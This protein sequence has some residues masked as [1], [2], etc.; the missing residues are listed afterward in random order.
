M[1]VCQAV[2]RG[3]GTVRRNGYSRSHGPACLWHGRVQKYGGHFQGLVPDVRLHV[4]DDDYECHIPEAA[5]FGFGVC[6]KR[7]CRPALDAS[8]RRYRQGCPQ[9]RRHHRPHGA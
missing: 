8:D 1:A 2:L 6:T 7:G 4:R 5:D 3:G 9:D